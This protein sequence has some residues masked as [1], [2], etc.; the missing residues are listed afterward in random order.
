M[1][2][3]IA[4]GRVF[5]PAQGWHGEVRDLYLEGERLVSRLPRVDKVI[6]ARDQAVVAGGIDLRGHLATY[7]L[8]FLRLWGMMPSPAKLGEAYAALGYTHV[9]E[10]FLTQTTAAY[11]HR[12]LAALPVVD[13]SASLVVNLREMD[14][15]LK[16]EDKLAEVMETLRFLLE[17]TRALNYR[18]VEP[19]VRHRQEFYRHRNIPVDKGLEILARLAQEGQTTFLL[20]TSPEILRTALP[21]PSAFHLSGVGAA[22]EDDELAAAAAAHLEKGASMDL[23]LI[24]PQRTAPG[25]SPPLLVDLGQSRPMSLGPSTDPARARRALKLALTLKENQAA[26]SGAG[27]GATVEHYPDFFAWLGDP[28]ARRLFWGDEVSPECYGFSQW[29][30]ATRTLPARLLGL[31]DRGHLR[32]GARADLALFDWPAGSEDRWPRRVKRCRMLIKGGEVVVEN[33]RLVRP[34]VKKAIYFR[35]TGAQS[36]PLVAELCGFRSFRAEN[37]WSWDEL[38]GAA[39]VKV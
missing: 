33:Y 18:V 11:V 1:R 12:E 27:I 21:Q 28:E 4:G 13:G 26:F 15:R 23:G 32:P 19:W 17:N 20:E 9:H 37:L 3:K 39:W 36:T 6:E 34:E 7:G 30:W 29:V 14:L 35:S 24:W 38:A 31:A 22:L 2:L 5:D 8:N 16:D 25:D 10:P